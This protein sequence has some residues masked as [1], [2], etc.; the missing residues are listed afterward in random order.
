LPQPRTV[1]RTVCS[2]SSISASNQKAEGRRQGT[3][4]LLA[5]CVEWAGRVWR[6]SYR[7]VQFQLFYVHVLPVDEAQQ[8]CL[9]SLQLYFN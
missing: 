9:A 6:A 2:N 4:K 5:A 3:A 1:Q 8:I 7:G